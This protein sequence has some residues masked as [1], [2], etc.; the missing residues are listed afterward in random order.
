MKNNVKGNRNIIGNNNNSGDTIINSHVNNTKVLNETLIRYGIEQKDVNELLTILKMERP[1][2]NH[3]QPGDYAQTWI[4]KIVKKAKD[5][6]GNI[7]LGITASMLAQCI[8][9]YYEIAQ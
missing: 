7:S 5:G 8:M 1:D 2:E 3:A 9:K 4:N 6:I